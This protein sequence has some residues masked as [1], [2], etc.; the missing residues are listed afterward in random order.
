MARRQ[1]SER[2]PRRTC[3]FRTETTAA[4]ADRPTPPRRRHGSAAH[5][6]GAHVPELVLLRHVL[7][8]RVLADMRQ[9]RGRVQPEERGV[10]VQR[11]RHQHDRVRVP[12]PDRGVPH[13]P[14]AARQRGRQGHMRRPVAHTHRAVRRRRAVLR[15]V[16]EE[17]LPA[18]EH[19]G[20]HT[21]GAPGHAG[22]LRHR[23]AADHQEQRLDHLTDGRPV[24]GRRAG[25]RC[26]VLISFFFTFICSSFIF[27]FSF[28][29]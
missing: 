26:V 4:A 12:V 9:V 29:F 8:V 16:A 2:H 23:V 5:V 19:P 27:F 1:S 22:V 15:A 25:T 20:L 11:V 3:T 13:V 7:H 21:A 10:H 28:F 14:V 6:R 24:S 17:D 18:G